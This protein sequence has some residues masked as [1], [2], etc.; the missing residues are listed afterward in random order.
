MLTDEELA[1]RAAA[2]FRAEHHNTRRIEESIERGKTSWIE[3]ALTNISYA[4]VAVL[5][6]PLSVGSAILAASVGT[7]VSRVSRGAYRMIRWLFGGR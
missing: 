3:D 7:V 1:R 4:V 2:R 6:P 5:I